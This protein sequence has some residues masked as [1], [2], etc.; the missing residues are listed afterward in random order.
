MAHDI[1]VE[2]IR[3]NELPELF[4][5]QRLSAQHLL[6]FIAWPGSACTVLADPQERLGV[7]LVWLPGM[8]VDVLDQLAREIPSEM[9]VQSADLR[10][11]YTMLIWR[12]PCGIEVR[13]STWE[14]QPHPFYWFNKSNADAKFG[15]V[16]FSEKGARCA[17][18]VLDEEAYDDLLTCLNASALSSGP[19]WKPWRIYDDEVMDRHEGMVDEP[20]AGV[21]VPAMLHRKQRD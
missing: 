8:K 13:L 7:I 4:G 17:T 5:E 15:V 14:M 3:L 6:D 20:E 21:I 11:C 10:T 1:T 2:A 16:F 9:N 18:H 19:N 12:A